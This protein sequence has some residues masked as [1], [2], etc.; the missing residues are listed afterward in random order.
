M[1]KDFRFL[2]LLGEW[3]VLLM[4]I[5]LRSLQGAALVV[6]GVEI[7]HRLGPEAALAFFAVSAVVV[8]FMG[9]LLAPLV[10]IGAGYALFEW[11]NY[12]P[13]LLTVSAFVVAAPYGSAIHALVASA[14]AEAE[15]QI[16]QTL[17][18]WRASRSGDEALAVPSDQGG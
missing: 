2:V 4:L 18:E 16:E 7:L 15:A 17:A 6:I 10:I 14:R 12:F 13:L 9:I 8:A 1:L 11:G 3:R 5:T